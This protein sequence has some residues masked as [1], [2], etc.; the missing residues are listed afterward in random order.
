M[1]HEQKVWCSDLLS[2]FEEGK[3]I[4][5]ETPDI[6]KGQSWIKR[7]QSGEIVEATE[8]PKV[9]RAEQA[10]G[11]LP[12]IFKINNKLIVVKEQLKELLTSFNLGNSHLHSVSIHDYWGQEEYPGPFFILNIAESI[13]VFDPDRSKGACRHYDYSPWHI[14]WAGVEP[15]DIA[16]KTNSI[17]HNEVDLWLDP[18]L[19]DVIF[20]TD[21]LALAI[22]EQ[23][24]ENFKL[25]PCNETG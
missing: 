1:D 23:Q 9:L 19:S 17:D 18:N 2:D 24:I 8:L 20:L 15:L 5:Y 14:K 11:S 25:Y 22:E 21:Q 7:Y 6:V 10:Y 12:Q 3:S 4:G 16:V 13:Q